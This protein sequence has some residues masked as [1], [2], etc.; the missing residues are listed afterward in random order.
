MVDF[1]D[2]EKL[3][4]KR[5]KEYIDYHHLNKGIYDNVTQTWVIEFN[6]LNDSKINY[7]DIYYAIEINS[8][9]PN[10]IPDSNIFIYSKPKVKL[11]YNIPPEKYISG[12]FNLT[13]NDTKQ[14]YFTE[15][16]KNI[17]NKI[18]IIELS[19]NY[20]NV[21]LSI[22]D[23][24]KS[25]NKSEVYAQIYRI[26]DIIDN[27]TIV[28]KDKDNT[29]NNPPIINYIFKYYYSDDIYYNSSYSS[30]ISCNYPPE[31]GKEKRSI[32]IKCNNIKFTKIK[33]KR[34]F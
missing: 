18:T 15:P 17:S 30:K 28:L 34:R 14:I 23:K 2:L 33:N 19:S 31:I 12:I 3:D 20:K 1:L 9:S 26:E 4:E 21:E 6:K 5:N 32:E 24:F 11:R 22:N 29:I 7:K 10:I 13:G 25:S 8:D 16:N 27:F